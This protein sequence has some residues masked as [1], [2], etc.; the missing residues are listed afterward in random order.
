[1]PLTKSKTMLW[2]RRALAVVVG[3]FVWAIA[4]SLLESAL[5]NAGTLATLASVPAIAVAAVGGLA[6]G[7]IGSR[8]SWVW[9]ALT[10]VVA[11]DALI[12]TFVAPSDSG[13]VLDLVLRA[14]PLVVMVASA[15]AISWLLSRRLAK[16]NN[17]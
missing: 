3:Y 4:F 6:T 2:A 1:M 9:I 15:A 13:L 11:V 14:L 10:V 16:G 12:A 8:S 7:W 5:Q 17:S